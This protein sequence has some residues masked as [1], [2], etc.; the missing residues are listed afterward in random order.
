MSVIETVSAHCREFDLTRLKSDRPTS[1]YFLIV[2]GEIMYVGQTTNI[3]QRIALHINAGREFDRVL[4]FVV[5]APDADAYEGALIRALNPTWSRR[6]P[7]DRGRDIEVL[8][9]LGLQPDATASEA[10][11][12]RS[13]REWHEARAAT[14]RHQAESDAR[15]IAMYGEDAS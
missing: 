9:T 4:Y 14:K 15:W 1:I 3:D 2:A 10:F 12:R 13:K 5:E 6:A 7:V 11:D 8:A